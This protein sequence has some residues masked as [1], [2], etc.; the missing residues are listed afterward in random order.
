[1]KKLIK[2]TIGVLIIALATAAFV[3]WQG[4]TAPGRTVPNQ[5]ANFQGKT[6]VLQVSP[7]S[8][9]YDWAVLTYDLGAYSG[10]VTI[11]VSMQ[12]WLD[13]PTKVVWQVNNN[14][15]PIIAGNT[16]ADLPARQ[17]LEVKGSNTI[18]LE[19]N[20][21]LYLSTHHFGNNI[22][23]YIDDI[24]ITINGNVVNT[25]VV[26]DTSLTA[27][28]TKWPFRVGVAV[29]DTSFSVVSP[30]RQLLRHFNV[31]VAE[32]R[33]KP[34]GIMPHPWTPTGAYRW[35]EA[36][37]MVNYAEANNQKIRGH[38]LIWH[39]SIPDAFFRGSGRQG[40]ATTD[41][42]YARMEHHIK[43]VFEKYRGRIEW[44]DV[45][46]EA[47]GDD[48][49]PR[50]PGNVA[51]TGTD[52]QSVFT[53]IMLDAGKTGTDRYEYV[54][55][56]FQ[57][58]RQYADANG[59]QNVKLF[60]TD[61]SMEIPGAKHNGFLR[62]LDYLIANNAPIDGVGVQGHYN[63][64]WPAVRDVSRGIDAFTS[65]RNPRTGQNLVIQVCELDISIYRRNETTWSNTGARGT[66]TLA[67][68]ELNTRLTAQAQRYREFFDMYLEKYNEGK[69]DMVL[70]WGIDD[71]TSWINE[72][73]VRGRTDHPL[74]F[75]RQ[76]QP[77]PAFHELIRGR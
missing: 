33:M 26:I 29:S 23:A 62:L 15:W 68:R 58:A 24:T 48:G 64:D 31:L 10:R 50:A 39:N 34:D 37:A 43:T 9:G 60:L 20:R 2:M 12:V 21:M 28:H 73:P 52:S 53:Q 25:P 14:N 54:L 72:F 42:L 4:I 71:G 35:A 55:K 18:T 41:E 1:M 32:N 6:N 47:V 74:L 67:E 65:R 8:G 75:N 30:Q 16:N 5:H 56:A 61:Y 70:I 63:H 77:K 51:G 3:S 44:W 49:N 69:L 59:G 40:R 7:G 66:L 36:D 57:F 22:T 13:R 76:Y 45:V 19:P 27:L 17:W 38:V 11:E 46:N